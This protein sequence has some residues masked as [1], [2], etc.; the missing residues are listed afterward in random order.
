MKEILIEI[1]DDNFLKL[2]ETMSETGLVNV[3]KAFSIE[4]NK[5]LDQYFQDDK[6]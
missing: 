1:S 5:A 6:N 3:N 4:I 2:L